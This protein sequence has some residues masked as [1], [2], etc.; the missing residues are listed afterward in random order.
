MERCIGKYLFNYNTINDILTPSQ[1]GFRNGDS[2]TNQLLHNYHTICE[3]DDNGKEVTAFFCDISK[4]LDRVWHESLL[5]K[6][7]TIG[8]S[9]SIVNWYF[10]FLSNPR[11]RVVING[12]ASDWA[13][14]LAGVPQGSS[15]GP[16]LF[17]FFYK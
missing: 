16:L 7:C 4:A 3:A 12:Q 11:Q 1:S 6:L 10:T 14:V 5:F 13:S 15:L 8:C 17:L 2:P 9:D